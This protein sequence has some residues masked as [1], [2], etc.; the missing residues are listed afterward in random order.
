[1]TPSNPEQ[2]AEVLFNA[3][4]I[5]RDRKRFNA[6]MAWTREE[7]AY[8]INELAKLDEAEAVKH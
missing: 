3:Q 1:M 8:F 2:D 4:E 5:R 6:A 7:L